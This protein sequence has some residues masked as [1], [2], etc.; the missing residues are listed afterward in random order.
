V[1]TKSNQVLAGVIAAET[2]DAITLRTPAE[3]RVPRASIKTMR[4]DRVSIMPQ[5][6]DAQMSKQ[7]LSDLLAF[8][9]TLK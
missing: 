9:Q 8:L 3:V 7:E 6:L 4:Q 1:Q 2:A 5:G